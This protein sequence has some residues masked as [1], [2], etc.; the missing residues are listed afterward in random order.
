M[1]VPLDGSDGDAII[2]AVEDL[3]EALARP[4]LPEG[5][6]VYVTGVGGL[7]ADLFAVFETLDSTLL[8]ATAGVVVLILLLVYRSPV[9]WVLPLL[10]A[11][12]AFTLAAALVYGL[13]RAGVLTVDGQG[14]GILTVLVFGAGTDYA[15]LLI[16]RYREELH[17]H[18][19]SWDAMRVALRGA[20]P[21]IV[22]SAATVVLGLLCLLASDLGSNRDLGPVAAL[23]IVAALLAMTTFL[24][25]LLVLCGRRVFW[26]RVPRHDG[27]QTEDTGVWHRVAETVG[28]RTRLVALST[29]GL[30]VVLCFGVLQLDASGIAAERGR[31][32]RRRV[33]G[34]AGRSSAST[35]RPAPARRRPSSGAAAQADALLA[36]V[37]GTPDVAPGRALRRAARR[38][39]RRR[40]TAGSWSTSCCPCPGEGEPGARAVNALRERVDAADPQAVVGGFTADR[41]RRPGGQPAR[42]AW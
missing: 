3:R 30:L 21:A 40:S 34:R 15:L 6:D 13:V 8:L 22:A 39:A 25:A 7:S 28:R 32:R 41:R 19:R 31:H 38:S 10:A 2:P 26:P 1:F 4:G 14:Q 23:G 5:L 9:L 35:T 42:P 33:G 17:R 24:P 11:G 29:G 37:R 12:L 27:L 18:E 16:A 36:A 20:V